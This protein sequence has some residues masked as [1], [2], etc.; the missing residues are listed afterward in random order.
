MEAPQI[1]NEEHNN[2]INRTII[3]RMG[4]YRV[5]GIVLSASP[6]LSN[7]ILV[8]TLEDGGT[9][10]EV[11]EHFQGQLAVQRQGHGLGA[12]SEPESSLPVKCQKAQGQ[13]FEQNP[14]GYKWN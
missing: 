3:T 6:E 12:G 4:V 2:T 5:L 9:D 8:M 11:K 1:S 13:I 14:G 7:L 10:L